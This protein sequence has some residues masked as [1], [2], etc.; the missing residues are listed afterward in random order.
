MAL[1][2][3]SHAMQDVR[4][5]A[6]DLSLFTTSEFDFVSCPAIHNRLFD[7]AQQVQSGC[8]RIV[9]WQGGDA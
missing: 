6:W 2:A 4:R 8:G 7:H 3:A 9:A 5:L 1:Q